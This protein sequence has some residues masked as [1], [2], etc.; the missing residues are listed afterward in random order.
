ME[1]AHQNLAR[2]HRKLGAD[3]DGPELPPAPKPKW[4]RWATYSGIV[5]QIEAGKARLDAVFLVGAQ[6]LIDRADK[7]ER[8]NRRRR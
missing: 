7:C 6:R 8:R 2:L 5:H 3:Y 1:R 4:M